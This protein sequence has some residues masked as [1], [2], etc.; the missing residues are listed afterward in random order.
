M[1]LHCQCETFQRKFQKCWIELAPIGTWP[2]HKSINFIQKRA[3][4]AVLKCAICGVQIERLRKGVGDVF[5]SFCV[6][7]DSLNWPRTSALALGY[8]SGDVLLYFA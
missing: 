3:S 1:L 6:N 5:L 8:G 7:D 4:A 2:L